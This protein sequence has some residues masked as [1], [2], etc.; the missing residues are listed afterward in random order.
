MVH[1]ES[2]AS[3]PQT[4]AATATGVGGNANTIRNVLKQYVYE[5]Q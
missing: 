1:A 5:N 2:E 3:M 4:S